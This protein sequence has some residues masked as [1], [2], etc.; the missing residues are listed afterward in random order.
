M[1]LSFPRIL[2]ASHK[3]HQTND[4]LNDT[5]THRLTLP[6]MAA[7]FDWLTDT[8]SNHLIRVNPLTA[9]WVLR[10]LIDFTLSN[11][12]RFYSSMGNPSAGRGLNNNRQNITKLKFGEFALLLCL[13]RTFWVLQLFW[14]QL[15]RFC[16][17]SPAMRQLTHHFTNRQNHYFTDQLL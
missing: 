4:W 13:R 2:R 10:A 17:T 6:L 9:E 14:Y 12:K 15:K 5:L 11:A 8:V 3:T 16:F 7:S 1:P